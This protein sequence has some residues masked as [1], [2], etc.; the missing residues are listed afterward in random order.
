M[1]DITILTADQIIDTINTKFDCDISQGTFRYK[2]ASG[3]IKVGD[4]AGTIR[5]DG[6]RAISVTANE[7][8]LAHKLI[9]LMANG[10]WPSGVLVHIS[11]D[12]S[13]NSISNI[14]ETSKSESCS[15]STIVRKNNTSTYKG[16][17]YDASH[18]CYRARVTNNGERIFLGNFPTAEEANQAILNYSK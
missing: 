8:H 2:K 14:K 6:Y 11:G 5:K 3:K 7:K 4:I 13:D 16:V 12:K 18:S 10:H 9:Y 1:S 15:S 17:A